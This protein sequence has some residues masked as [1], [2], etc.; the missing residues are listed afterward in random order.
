MN[1][2]AMVILALCSH[3]CA[4]EPLRPLEL[5]EWNALAKSLAEHGLEP[6]SILDLSEREREDVLFVDRENSERISRLLDRSAS[7][8]FAL[9]KLNNSGIFV[10]TRAEP[11]YP[12]R[13]KKLLGNSSPAL[14][15]YAG[16]LCLLEKPAIGYAGSRSASEKD[17]Q[18]TVRTV[19][20]TVS[21]GFFVVSGGAKG[22]DAT[23]E[24]TALNMGSCAISFLSDSMLRKIKRPAVLKSVQE[25]RML[26]LSSVNPDAGFQAGTAM[27]RNRY[28]Y[29]H[30][31]CTVIVRSDYNKGG[32]WSGA[33]ENLRHRWSATLC[34]NNPQ[35]DGN[36]ALIQ[37]GAI[38][39]DESWD[40]NPSTLPPTDSEAE[41]LS[42][43]S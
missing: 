14:F 17:I 38:P 12:Q 42:L 15:Y 35:Y 36:R 3:L 22:I 7:L 18:F 19:Q 10:V 6:R 37:K 40:G 31:V 13:L 1:D 5:R 21:K 24:E 20:K 27:M 8:I 41:Q 32:T 23:A 43:F 33:T 26:L 16:D 11:S 28:I 29:A 25:K 39:L 4:E 30:S 34:W 9:N 2:N